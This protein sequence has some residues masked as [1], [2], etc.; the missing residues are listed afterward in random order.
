MINTGSTF[1]GIALNS[2]KAG[3]PIMIAMD[4]IFE[5]AGSGLISAGDIIGDIWTVKR[6]IEEERDTSLI[7][8]TK[9]RTL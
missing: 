9:L 6:K 4:G 2:A 1:V 7:I 5:L 3:D 8:N